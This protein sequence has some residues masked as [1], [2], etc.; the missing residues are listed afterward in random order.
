M[1]TFGNSVISTNVKNKGL[2]PKFA[3]DGRQFCSQMNS[4]DE[5]NFFLK[6][7]P[8]ARVDGDEDGIPCENDTR[9]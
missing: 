1:T 5:A 9:F 2:A 7:C 3:C 4:R 6:N 8:K